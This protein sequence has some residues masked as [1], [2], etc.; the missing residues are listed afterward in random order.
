MIS[1]N[2]KVS[3][4]MSVQALYSKS[5]QRK[6]QIL[7]VVPGS[8]IFAGI[9]RVVDEI[10]TELA[11]TYRSSVDVDVLY[12]S[13]FKNYEIGARPYQKIQT[14]PTSRTGLMLTLR[15]VI[16]KKDYDL[17]VVPQIEATVITWVACF[18]LSPKIVLHLHGNPKRERSHIKAKILF[19]LLKAV[20]LPRLAGVFGT[21]PRQ[22]ESFKAMFPS[23]RLHVWV[24][25][26]VRRFDTQALDNR[27]VD[28]RGQPEMVT[29]VC[30]ARF[31]YQKGQDLLIAAF[32]QLCQRRKNVKLRIVGYGPEET[33]IRASIAK[34]GLADAVTIEHHPDNPAVPL[35]SSDV[36]VCSSRWEGWSLAICEALRF[37]LPV[38]SM[39]CE[40]GPSDILTDSR[41]GRLV[42]FSETRESVEALV[43]ALVHY[44]DNIADERKEA[45][46][47]KLYVERF[48]VDR[49]VHVHADA[50]SLAVRGGVEAVV[51]A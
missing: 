37:G 45:E 14:A 34:L 44:S 31:A 7:Y 18:G 26:P 20:V 13:H 16:G 43:E 33:D 24:P 4:G 5:S 46:F 22:L 39:D 21:S 48:S 2:A 49:V 40:F 1:P 19:C 17:V 41:L 32:A 30:V 29:F 38:V 8:K 11:E 23:D 3:E 9:E 27:V 10:S 25:N 51:I 6:L 50:I 28:G 35:A 36:F 15:D 12:T 47:R 42:P